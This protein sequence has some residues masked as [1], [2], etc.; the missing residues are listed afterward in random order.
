MTR[1]QAIKILKWIAEIYDNKNTVYEN[2]A[3]T[4]A[5]EAIEE[6]Q[7]GGWI[8]VKDALPE[9]YVAVMVYCPDT[10]MTRKIE[11]DY[12]ERLHWSDE[13]KHGPVTHWQPLPGPPK[14]ESL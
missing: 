4:M 11:I 5:I 10:K 1:T 7:A 9:V 12:L 3:L 14:E 2:Q 13:W 6:K 8:S